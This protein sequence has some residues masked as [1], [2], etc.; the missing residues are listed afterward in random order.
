MTETTE[1]QIVPVKE[2]SILPDNTVHFNTIDFFRKS[3]VKIIRAK[4]QE[5]TLLTLPQGNK[6]KLQLEKD[7]QVEYFLSSPKIKN[8]QTFYTSIALKKGC[9]TE[10]I[11]EMW[12]R[13]QNVDMI[14]YLEDFK[15][16]L[17]EMKNGHAN[18][19]DEKNEEGITF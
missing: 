12:E 11:P 6:S 18:S 2:Y 4:K 13:F 7:L 17:P 5:I 10:K 9:A 3:M 15:K 19:E 14:E 1:N 16:T 8:G